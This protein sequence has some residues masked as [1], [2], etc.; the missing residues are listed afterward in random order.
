MSKKLIY[1]TSFV[2]LLALAGT[3]VTL[4]DVWEGRVIE[5]TD[6]TE[7]LDPSGTPEA[8]S[9]DL[10]MPY[11][12]PGMGDKQLVAIRWQN[13]GVPKG[14][15]I[16]EAW[17]EF[18]VDEVEEDLHVSVIIEGELNPNPP[19]FTETTPSEIADRQP[20]TTAQAIYEPEHWAAEGDKHRTSD[21][22]AVIQEIVN[23]DGWVAGNAL[24]LIIRDNPDNPSKGNRTA[25]ADS[26]G[27][28]IATLLH[29]EYTLGN[30]G[31]PSPADGAI[32]V[33]RDVVLSWK[34]GLS[35]A[36][37]NGHTVYFSKNF[38]DVNDGIGGITQSDSSYTPGRLDFGTTYYWRVDELSG[39]PDNLLFEGDVWSFTTELHAYPVENVTATASSAYQADMGPENTI[40][41]SGMDA[42]DLHSTEETAIWLSGTEP[43]GAW[44]AYEFDKV[45][46]LHE[47]RV[48]NYNQ[49][50]ESFVGY[51][52][53]DVTV[54]YSANGTDYTTL[55]TTHQFAQAPGADG[56]ANN[57]T[58]DFGGAA[59]K[60]VRLTANSNWG[61]ILPQYGLSEVRF[62]YIP[63]NATKPY[64]DS[65]ATGVDVDVV[66]GW[67]A[68]R[69]AVTHDVYVSADEQAVIDG[70]APVAAVTETS[71]GP[72]ALDLDTT[73]YWKV[74][75]VNEAEIPSTWESAIWS[76]ATT[77]HLI[78]DD[79]ESY[80]DLDPEDPESNRIFNVW[81]DGYEVPTNG[82]LV[83]YESAPFCEQTI[84]YSGNQSMP[85]FYS[86]TDGAASSEAE[87]T[88]TPAQNWTESQ[89]KTLAVHFHGAE[90]NTGQ[91]YVKINGTK[92]PYD[93]QAYHLALTGWQAWN[94]DL[95]SSGASLQDV[96]KLAIGIDGN[97]ARGTLYVDDIGLYA[98]SR[99]FISP[100]EPD[101]SRLIGHWKFDGDTQD[102]S[103][104]GNHGTSGIIPAVFV[105]GKVGSNAVDLQG[106]DYV[107]IDGVVNDITSTDITISIW[108]K[109]TQSDEGELVA[110]N[111]ATSDHPFMFGLQIGNPYVNDGG[112]TT[113][114]PPVND[115]QWHLLTYVRSGNTGHVYVDG[116]LRGTY[117]AGFSLDSITRWSIGQEWD[118]GPSD[119]YEGAVDDVRF[120]DYPLSEGEIAWLAGRT[121][122]F[123]KPF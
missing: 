63:V 68:G 57:T 49:M 48:W 102:S 111:T 66:L 99:E 88:L 11:E 98:R 43:M 56:Y 2:L 97:G 121:Q 94:I 9:G 41:G 50:I 64:P 72:L 117:P 78:V 38:N 55:G 93:G 107:M 35:A 67:R 123:D 69:E 45:Y 106:S 40:N 95:A 23:Q 26:G 73:H 89:V 70:T 115:D 74:N 81:I 29:I 19:T 44:I 105:A 85:V 100:S 21:L 60:Y 71:H 79:F 114:G 33:S 96:T 52:F 112:D 83:G 86:N 17:I 30:A 14:A 10:E 28:D 80:N 104:R 36:P 8:G 84:V 31:A 59:A 15:A 76:F 65:G 109:T 34:P 5:D 18:T 24:V 101:D 46:K 4:G 90:G 82:A 58:I 12:D 113:F 32:D 87:L 91:L 118:T 108:I 54:E 3:N 75:E 1:L 103:G 110:A 92:V 62:F 25:E 53:K 7:E 6:D 22:S 39:P 51:G 122:P 13:V 20:R 16:L 37:V 47:M 116:T 77:D 61:G 119:E 120:Y 42:I 27:S